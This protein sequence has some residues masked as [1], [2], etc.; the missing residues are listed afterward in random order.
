MESAGR[1]PAP[2]GVAHAYDLLRTHDPT[3]PNGI[4]GP[5]ARTARKAGPQGLR[6]LWRRPRLRSPLYPKGTPRAAGP[7]GAASPT[8][9]GFTGSSSLPPVYF[10]V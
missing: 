6:A 10:Q 9:H 4:R 5:Q 3:K 1:R 2:R 7:H 8:P